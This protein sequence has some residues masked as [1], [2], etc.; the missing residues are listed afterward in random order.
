MLRVAPSPRAAALGARAAV[1]GA[2]Q[3]PAALSLCA[4][5]AT[6]ARRAPRCVAALAQP[7]VGLD[8]VRATAEARRDRAQL[9]PD[10]PFGAA[11]WV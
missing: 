6:P 7:G 9:A 11:G 10:Q 5:R 2:P 1:R 4:R 3:R 8:Q